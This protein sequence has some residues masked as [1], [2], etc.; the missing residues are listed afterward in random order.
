MKIHKISRDK[1]QIIYSK[2]C[3][4]WQG[5]I[6]TELVNQKFNSEISINNDILLEAYKEGDSGHKKLLDSYFELDHP[7]SLFNVKTYKEVCKELKEDEIEESD[8]KFLS[9]EK[10]AKACAQAQL[11]Q[12][13]TFYNGDWKVNIKSDSQYRY[14]PYFGTGHG[15]LVF[16]GSS[17]NSSSVIGVT[18]YF[19]DKETSDF[20]GQTYIEIYKNLY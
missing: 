5:K 9:K 10:R 15:G 14:F 13:E 20:V 2:V 8:F 11:Q 3:S 19:K 1:L 4:K 6:D 17:Y 7:K 18:A 12:I 16:D